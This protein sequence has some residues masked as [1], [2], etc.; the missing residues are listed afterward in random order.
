MPVISAALRSLKAALKNNAAFVALV[1]LLAF[2]CL[3]TNN[4]VSWITFSNLFTQASRV[5]LV[6]LGMTLIISTGGIDISVGS[7]MGLS[8]TISALFLLNQDPLGFAVSLAV[9]VAFG[10]L[11][12][13]MISKFAILPLIVTLALRYILRGL[14]LGLS[15]RGSVTYNAPALTNFFT[16]PIAGRI[17]VHFFIIL[18]A[19]AI[20]YVIVNRMKFGFQIEAYGNNPVAARICGIDTARIIVICY[21]VS[22]MFAW[23][24]GLL[25][26]FMVSSA[27]PSKIGLD[28]ETDAIASVVVGGTPITG[29]YPNIIGTVC[30]AFLLQ[31]ITMMCNMNNIPYSAA[32]MIKAGI[33]VLALFYHGLNK[34]K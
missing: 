28:M 2:N 30:G 22:A 19:V 6:S 29:G 34:K 8:A 25:E 24:S 14:S 26:M 17:P 4:F 18:L 7:A 3:F 5:V 27:D 11:C 31:L 33:I 9:A 16:T 23:A 21:V 13:L 12:G 1:L 20:M 32:L 15:G 10:A